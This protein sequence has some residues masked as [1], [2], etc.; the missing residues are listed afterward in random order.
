MERVGSYTMQAR[1]RVLAIVSLVAALAAPALAIVPADAVS[2]GRTAVS[3]SGPVVSDPDLAGKQL[4]ERF[5]RL[6]VKKDLPK[7][8][9]FL[10]PN[11]QVL[12]ADGSYSKKAE[13]F[14]A[15]PT[16]HSFAINDA[17][18]TFSGNTLVVRYL[19]RV[20]GTANGKPYTAGFA[21]RL[22]TFIWTAGQWRLL[23]HANFNSLTA[24][25]SGNTG[26]TGNS[27]DSGNTGNGGQGD[28]SGHDHGEH[29]H[30]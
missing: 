24:P 13:Y 10:V 30:D 14:R 19:A 27:G 25:Q 26:N 16:I 5:L 18:G 15:L 28:H 9:Q 11:F 17:H 3:V 29:N 20:S 22:S 8:R 1:I 23:S 6:L 12:R 7:L 2:T 4:A 21:P